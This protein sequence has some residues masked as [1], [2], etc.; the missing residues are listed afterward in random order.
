MFRRNRSKAR[1]RLVVAA[2]ME[3]DTARSHLLAVDLGL[4]M[5]LALYNSNGCLCWHRSHN[6]GSSERLRRAA[7][8]ILATERSLAWVILEG[9]S[10]LGV[11]WS[12]PA[13]KRG[14]SARL[15]SAHQWRQVLMHPCEQRSGVEA[16]RHARQL[17]QR[18]IAW[19]GIPKTT[20]LRTDAAEAILIGLWACLEIGWLKQLPLTLN[21][22]FRAH[23]TSHP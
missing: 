5:G 21:S 14:V 7:W 19:S 6:I 17:A 16:K 20:S 23:P 11:I 3:C 4:K 22:A 18:V 12:K 1:L 9:D 8:Q 2:K 13:Q 10:R 15:V